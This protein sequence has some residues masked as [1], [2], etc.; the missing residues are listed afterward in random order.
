MIEP[1]PRLAVIQPLPGIGDMVWHLPHI[2]AIAEAARHPVTLIAKPRSAAKEIFAAEH[3]IADVFWMDRN[4][5]RRRGAHDG[6]LGLMKLIAAMRER[7]FETVVILHH[8][9]TLAFAAMAAGVPR[10][11]GYGYRWQ[12]PFLNRPPYLPQSAL[13]LHPY[14]QATAWLKVAGIPQIQ[15]EPRLPVADQARRAIAG[16]LGSRAT[17]LVAIGIG[18]SE[19]YKQWGAERFAA[20]IRRLLA[21]GWEN[22]VLIGGPSEAALAAEIAERLADHAGHVVPALG[23]TLA[24]IAALFEVSGFYAGNDTG[25]M[26]MAAAVGIRTYALFGA[27]PPFHHASA[28][29]P[30]TPPDGRIDKTNGMARIGVEDLVGAITV[31]RG[32]LGPTGQAGSRQHAG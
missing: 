27:T 2:R 6:P 13:P 10:R 24:E 11:H 23:W 32:G 12:R 16:R 4:P 22:A 30:V 31:D 20:F 1:S 21:A 9:R 17:S 5:D 26:N 7:R 25:V 8:S 15:A 18:T 3:T 19:P 29:V 28:I 14:D